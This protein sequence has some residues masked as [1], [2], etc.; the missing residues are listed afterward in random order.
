MWTLLRKHI[1]GLSCPFLINF[2][3]MLSDLAWI[4]RFYH[5]TLEY[6]LLTL[7]KWPECEQLYRMMPTELKMFDKR[8]VNIDYLFKVFM[9]HLNPRHR[10]RHGPITNTISFWLGLVLRQHFFCITSI[11]RLCVRCIFYWKWWNVEQTFTW[12]SYT[13]RLWIFNSGFG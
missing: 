12:R 7:L 3:S 13:G 10:H 4:S 2:W 1:H 8:I 5:T 11:G 6:M 9:D